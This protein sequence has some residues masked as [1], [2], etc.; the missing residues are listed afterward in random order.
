[1]NRGPFIAFAFALGELMLLTADGTYSV[2]FSGALR[3]HV[4]GK[5]TAAPSAVLSDAGPSFTVVLHFP[6]GTAPG[7]PSGQEFLAFATESR[8]RPSPGHYRLVEPGDTASGR[9]QEVVLTG[10]ERIPWGCVD[11]ALDL[12]TSRTSRTGLVGSFTVKFVRSRDPANRGGPRDTLVVAGR[13]DI[14]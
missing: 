2:D 1:M 4:V 8:S 14:P 10:D 6:K 13:F 9:H 7:D 3:A 12:N 5:A 11:G